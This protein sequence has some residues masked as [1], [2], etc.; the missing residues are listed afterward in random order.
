MDTATILLELK[1]ISEYYF[2]K[3]DYVSAGQIN[4][5]MEVAEDYATSIEPGEVTGKGNEHETIVSAWDDKG[6]ILFIKTFHYDT[7]KEECQAAFSH[8]SGGNFA[9][10]A[11]GRIDTFKLNRNDE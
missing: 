9:N 5:A 4:R 3:K 6:K 8:V 1:K 7:Q 2:D 10:Y 11:M